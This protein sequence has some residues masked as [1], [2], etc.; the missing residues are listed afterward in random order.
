MTNPWTLSLKTME[1]DTGNVKSAER[2]TKIRP[3]FGD[4]WKNMLRASNIIVK[5][6]LLSGRRGR[7]SEGII[8][9][10][11]SFKMSALN[12]ELFSI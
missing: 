11:T 7:L 8:L 1:S 12:F 6:A 4:T 2:L 9:G 5:T 10:I 3:I